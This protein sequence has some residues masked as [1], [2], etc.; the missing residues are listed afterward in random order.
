MLAK[1]FLYQTVT[2]S[3]RTDDSICALALERNEEATEIIQ[4]KLLKTWLQ[5]GL[6]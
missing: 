4:N 1:I 2:K 3:I 5:A 6:F